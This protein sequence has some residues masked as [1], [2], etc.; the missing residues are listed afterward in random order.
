MN[1]LG[2]FVQ[3]TESSGGSENTS[4]MSGLSKGAIAGIVIR[5]VIVVGLGVGVVATIMLKNKQ[6]QEEIII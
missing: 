5:C 3:S 1:S 6:K 2:N 4:K